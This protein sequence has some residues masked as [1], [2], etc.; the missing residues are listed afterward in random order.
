VLLTKSFPAD[1][2]RR[3]L[4]SWDWLGL[5]GRAPVLASLFGDL[6][7]QDETGYWFLDSLEGALD[8]IATTR[9]EL[10]ALLDSE[11]GQDRY[12]LG[13]LAMAAERRGLRLQPGGGL[14]LPSAAD[15][16][17]RMDVESIVTMDFVV[18]LHIAG[19]VHWQVRERAPGTPGASITLRPGA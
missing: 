11:G 15:P 1:S 14:L 12:L 3:A 9:D 18:A 4:E 19:Q 17:G 10:H 8:R 16:R 13:G 2:Y 5:G 6:F 7:L